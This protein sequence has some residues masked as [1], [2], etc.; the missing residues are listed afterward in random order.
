MK[1]ND[2]ILQ[3][4]IPEFV[5]LFISANFCDDFGYSEL[6]NKEVEKWLSFIKQ[7]DNNFFK[8]NIKRIR[9]EKQRDELLGEYKSAYFIESKLKGKILEFEPSGKNRYKLDFRFQDKDGLEWFAEVKSPSWRNEVVQEIERQSLEG[10][11]KKIKSFQVIK[12]DTYQSSI[13]CPKCQRAISFTVINRSLDRSIV[14]ERIK[15]VKCNDCKKTV[16]QLS[17]KD[18]IKC[19]KN[20]LNQP[21]FLSGEG[22]TIS[23]ENAIKDSV[24]NSIDKFLPDK[25]NLLIITPNMFADTVG[26]SSLFSGEQTRKIVNDIDNT[27]VISRVLILEVELRDKFQYRSNFVNIKRQ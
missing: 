5:N 24:K 25:N 6:W 20:R 7:K 12:L 14:N 2:A 27:A 1:Y 19:I 10:L 11:N 17:E 23:I 18:R 26:F 4:N 21:Q 8:Q 15:N 3:Q 16:W 9:R 13:P 22:R